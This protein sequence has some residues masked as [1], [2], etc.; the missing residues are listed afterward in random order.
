MGV[1]DWLRDRVMPKPEDKPIPNPLVQRPM[2]STAWPTG[3]DLARVLRAMECQDPDGWAIVL[4]EPVRTYG[5]VTP[6]RLGA[7]LAET[8]HES[9]GGVRLVE[10]LTYRTADRIQAVFGTIR[11]PTEQ[12]AEPF[13]RSPVKLAN[14]VYAN[15]L[16][17]GPPESGDGWRFR[18]RGLLQITGRTNYAI[19]AQ[20]LGR[21]LDDAFLGWCCT[22]AGA[23]MTA[24]WW[25]SANGCNGIAD[26]GDTEAIRK[27]VNGPK[28][29]GLAEVRRLERAAAAALAA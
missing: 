5:I 21:D 2:P 20:S 17:N 26:R 27:R 9:M 19:A 16:G 7:F 14:F 28:A 24:C 23:A 10:D 12:S 6:Q 15:R 22:R 18:G 13:I 1:L 3:L 11:F 25:W 29:L 4:A 8:M